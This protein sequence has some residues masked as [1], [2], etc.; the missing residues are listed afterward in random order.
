[1]DDLLG[2]CLKGD[3]RAWDVFVGR[4][5]PVIIAAAR[6][7]GVSSSASYQQA[8]E[9]ICQEVF[10]RLVKNN[11]HLLKTYDPQRASLT[12]WLTI[13]AR[14]TAIDSLR[15]KKLSTISLQQAPP[16]QSVDRQLLVESS[17][18]TQELLAGPITAREKLVLHLLFDRQMDTKTIAELL[19]ITP[20]TVRSTKHKA[21]VKL[22]RFFAKKNSS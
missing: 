19:N 6:R 15:R 21:I 20:Q 1:M 12:T 16:A 8:A 17:D 5:A 7:A 9:D 11:F 13:V 2:K 4:Y 18:V 3:K 14:S 10:L 22:R